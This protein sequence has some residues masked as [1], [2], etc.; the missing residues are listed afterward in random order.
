MRL[1]RSTTNAS[2][3]ICTRSGISTATSRA[4]V[5]CSRPRGDTPRPQISPQGLPGGVLS[6][7]F[8]VAYDLVVGN[9]RF[10]SA[11]F[12]VGDETSVGKA[13]LHEILPLISG[14]C[15]VR[16]RRQQCVVP[17]KLDGGAYGPNRPLV[18]RIR[19]R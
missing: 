19:T 7:F 5:L 2:S 16:V 9:C 12:V 4:W 6:T 10:E 17:F 15:R 14:D 8:E 3:S 11:D 13:T 18:L 1:S